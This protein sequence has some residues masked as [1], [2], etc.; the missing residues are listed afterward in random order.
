MVKIKQIREAL[1]SNPNVI[2]VGKPKITN[3]LRKEKYLGGTGPSYS[4]TAYDEFYR[5]APKNGLYTLVEL[6]SFTRNLFPEIDQKF[7]NNFYLERGGWSRKR[8]RR[9]LYLAMLSFREK[10][11]EERRVTQRSISLDDKELL[12]DVDGFENGG[13]EIRVE[14]MIPYEKVLHLWVYPDERL[15]RDVLERDVGVAIPWRTV[16]KYRR[17][18]K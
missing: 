3:D 14:K 6:Q 2:I 18:R 16:Q 11:G 17:M 10:I 1:E 4:F 9:D 7:I 5:I 12:K 15:A 8:L 13:I